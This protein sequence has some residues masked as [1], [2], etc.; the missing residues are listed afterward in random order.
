MSKILVFGGTRFFGKALVEQLLEA[1]HEVTIATRG[2]ASD[3][4]GER[5]DRW[6][7]D[8]RDRGS[9][10]SHLHGQSF[11]VVFDNICYGPDDAKMMVEELEGKVGRYVLT[12]S[13]AVYDKGL[14]MAESE[15][16][17]YHYDIVYGP[18]TDFSYAEGKRLA[19]A[20]LFQQEAFPVVAVRFPVVL[21]SDDYTNRLRFYCDSILHGKPIAVVEGEIDFVLAREAGRFLMFIGETDFQG[22]INACSDGAV[23][24]SEII[25]LI[26][27]RAGREAILSSD[28]EETPYNPYMNMTTSNA[29]A[30]E[31]GFS[32]EK[33]KEYLPFLIDQYIKEAKK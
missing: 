23:T 21:G 10:Q 32:F 11:D 13:K 9:L 25:Q 2:L 26:E 33:T 18:Y 24:T 15:F 14:N 28:G 17:P 3:P 30:V 4:F 20:V 16:D 5:V 27:L 22:P 6:K 12:S 8:R 19:E 7:V 29:K 31:L 1:G